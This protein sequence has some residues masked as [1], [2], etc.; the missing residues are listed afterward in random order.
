MNR[1]SDLYAHACT[2]QCQMPCTTLH[3]GA[4]AVVHVKRT[5]AVRTLQRVVPLQSQAPTQTPRQQA[6]GSRYLSPTP[7]RIMY[8]HCSSDYTTRVVLFLAQHYLLHNV[9]D[10]GHLGL[11]GTFQVP[12][13]AY[14]DLPAGQVNPV[15]YRLM[16]TVTGVGVFMASL[17]RC[18]GHPRPSQV[19]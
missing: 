15:L 12:F 18:F 4:C 10:H 19:H 2:A 13:P 7:S 6:V 8:S 5:M 14:K 16:I 1:D 17:Y 3:T 11:A 9:F